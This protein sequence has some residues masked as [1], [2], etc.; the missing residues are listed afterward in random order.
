[1]KTLKMKEKKKRLYLLSPFTFTFLS[2][3]DLHIYICLVYVGVFGQSEA[4]LRDTVGLVPDHQ[5]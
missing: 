1:M 2:P 3:F 5:H 4:Y